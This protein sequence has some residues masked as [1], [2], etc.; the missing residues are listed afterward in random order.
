M[1]GRGEVQGC[2]R[3]MLGIPACLVAYLSLLM[4]VKVTY[5]GTLRVAY[6]CKAEVTG[7]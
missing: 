4:T 7:H 1:S 2:F 5:K 6:V 3:R